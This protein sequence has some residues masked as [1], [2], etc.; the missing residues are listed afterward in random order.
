MVTSYTPE[1]PDNKSI[2]KTA[3]VLENFA[4]A[5]KAFNKETAKQTNKVV[6]LT[7]VMAVLTAVMTL[8]LFVQI[9]IAWPK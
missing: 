3:E 4:N 1:S 9:W 6:R 5:T 8:G 7:V 2:K